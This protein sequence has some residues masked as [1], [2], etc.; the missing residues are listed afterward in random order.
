MIYNGRVY[1]LS[2]FFFGVAELTVFKSYV[3]EIYLFNSD[4]RKKDIATLQSLYR[5]ISVLPDRNG[6]P[7][8]EFV[9]SVEDMA[10][11]PSEPFWALARRPQDDNL[12]LM[13]DFG[14]WSCRRSY[15][16]RKRMILGGTRTG[17]YFGGENCPWHRN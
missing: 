9:V 2:Q 6:I 10:E 11:Y 3:D 7:N 1:S 16:M 17:N 14:F 8:I 13:P 12:W 15:L 5:A 4:H